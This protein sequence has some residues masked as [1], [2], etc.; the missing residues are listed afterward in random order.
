MRGMGYFSE[1]APRRDNLIDSVPNVGCPTVSVSDVYSVATL[2]SHVL[3]LPVRDRIVG[4]ILIIDYVEID[5]QRANIGAALTNFPGYF[6]IDSMGLLLGR[7][8]AGKTRLLLNVAEVLTK[9]APYSGQG[10]W[11]GR[12]SRRGKDI[13]SDAK[14]PPTGYGVVYY[15]PIPYR[16]TIAEN[17]RFVDASTIAEHTLRSNMFKQLH[18]VSEA[19]GEPSRLLVRLS[20]PRSIL[21]TLV[22]PLILET[23]CQLSDSQME[24]LRLDLVASAGGPLEG[25]ATHDFIRLLNKWLDSELEKRGADFRLVALAS[26]EHQAQILSQRAHAVI[27]FL[28]RAELAT[29]PSAQNSNDQKSREKALRDFNNIFYNTLRVHSLRGK[30]THIDNDA[31]VGIEFEAS[32]PSLFEEAAPSKMAVHIGWE[33]HSS[34]LLSLVQ[35]FSR[36]EAS[37]KRLKRR[38]IKS[39]LLLID[40]GDAYL[41]LDWQSLYVDYLNWFLARLK[42]SYR[43]DSLQ[44]LLATHSP[45][46][47]GDFPSQMVQRL[48]TNRG[49]GLPTIGYS[50]DSNGSRDFKTFGN[51]LDTLVLDTFGTPSIGAFAAKKIQELRTKFIANSLSEDDFYLIEQ[52]GDEGLR[53]AVLSKADDEES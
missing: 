30:A 34:G 47:S 53:R 37:V 4:A 11:T 50:L 33:N 29:F 22:V 38:R 15:T 48:E 52:I 12:T 9:G 5:G 14:D 20:Y 26:L 31:T 25:A 1:V 23:P 2:A 19:L 45:I 44:A 16:R 3:L 18:A 39:I 36:L 32:D 40:E 24:R 13:Q 46:I 41:H 7:N 51:S 6:N 27:A 42:E 28:T 8:G 21:K 17:Y 43:L 10:H 35:L 49:L